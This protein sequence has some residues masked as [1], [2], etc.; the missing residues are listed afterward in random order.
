MCRHL[1]EVAAAHPAE[2]DAVVE[3]DGAGILFAD[4]FA[5][6][7]AIKKT[8]RESTGICSASS[9]GA[10]SQRASNEASATCLELAVQFDGLLTSAVA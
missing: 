2:R 8:S 4:L 3:E 9:A 10:D 6:G 1:E 7:L 5:P